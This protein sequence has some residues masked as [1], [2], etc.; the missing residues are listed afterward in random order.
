MLHTSSKIYYSNTSTVPNVG[1]IIKILK[2]TF[3]KKILQ[4]NRVFMNFSYLTIFTL[5]KSVWSYTEM[6]TSQP[7]RAK[8]S[9]RRKGATVQL[10]TH[11][12][13]LA[14]QQ[15]I[16]RSLANSILVSLILHQLGG[17][18]LTESTKS[19]SLHFKWIYPQLLLSLKT[20]GTL[21]LPKQFVAFF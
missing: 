9:G 20:G 14:R 2:Y 18:C 3:L 13:K 17:K 5:S 12:L 19:Q 6:D 21:Y 15:S 8:G 11:Q 16:L 10:L 1:Y 7:V 4:I